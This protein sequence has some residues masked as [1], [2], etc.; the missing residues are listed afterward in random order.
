MPRSVKRAVVQPLPVYMSVFKSHEF[1]LNAIVHAHTGHLSSTRISL[2]RPPTD[3]VLLHP[4]VLLLCNLSRSLRL[5]Q[6]LILAEPRLDRLDAAGDGTVPPDL[7]H[8]S[9]DKQATH[10]HSP[11]TV[12]TICVLYNAQG[13]I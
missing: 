12:E 9:V 2:Y 7:I 10:T 6:P 8:S 1:V 13:R 5:H 4:L 11:K 3:D